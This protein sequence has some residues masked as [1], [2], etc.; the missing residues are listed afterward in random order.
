MVDFGVDLAIGFVVDLVV[1]VVF[2]APLLPF[3][4]WTV[5]VCGNLLAQKAFAGP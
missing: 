5:T 2:G 3:P 1:D 4:A